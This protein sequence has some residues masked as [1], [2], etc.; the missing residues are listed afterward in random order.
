MSEQEYDYYLNII[1]D[2]TEDEREQEI[3]HIRDE[4][5]HR[6]PGCSYV[7]PAPTESY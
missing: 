5:G 2:M 4:D 7:R 6:V 1:A 3:I